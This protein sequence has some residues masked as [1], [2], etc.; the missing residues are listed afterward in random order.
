LFKNAEVSR[1]KSVSLSRCNAAITAIKRPR[2]EDCKLE[3]SLSYIVIL[4]L[5]K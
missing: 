5:T 1:V 3:A 2:Q 4:C